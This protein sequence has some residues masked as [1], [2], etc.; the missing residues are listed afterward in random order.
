MTNQEIKIQALRLV[1]KVV[2]LKYNVGNGCYSDKKEL[3]KEEARLQGVKTWAIQ[4]D[5]IQDIKHYLV[6]K[7]WGMG[8]NFYASEVSK[9]FHA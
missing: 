6:S 3:E 1:D 8:M 9:I 7:S 5:M 4:N 2:T